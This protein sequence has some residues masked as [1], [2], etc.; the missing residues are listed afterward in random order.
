M[1]KKI[2]LISKIVAF[3]LAAIALIFLILLMANP[4]SDAIIGNY[5]VL[6][7]IT[8]GI[9]VVVALI[10]PIVRMILNPKQAVKGLLVIAGIFVLGLISYLLSS[11]SFPVQE[12]ERMHVTDSTSIWV[13]AGLNLTYIVGIATI[14][15]AIF[16]AIKKSIL[17]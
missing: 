13:G 15:A 9:A 5:L 17:K 2:I 4:T 16:L 14:L 12:L 7:Y 10:F 3:S 6:A 8:V 1:S 11:N